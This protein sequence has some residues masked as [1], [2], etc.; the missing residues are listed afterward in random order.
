M[1]GKA[2]LND[3]L[4]DKGLDDQHVASIDD[5][6]E[7]SLEALRDTLSR[8]EERKSLQSLLN[9]RGFHQ[10]RAWIDRE[11]AAVSKGGEGDG[12]TEIPTETILGE[13]ARLVLKVLLDGQV[14]PF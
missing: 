8:M 2:D 1:G 13:R 11:W 3:E 12:R 6:H 5:L 7:L 9:E 4:D 10:I 14:F